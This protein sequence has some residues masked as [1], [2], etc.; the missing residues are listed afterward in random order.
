M[1]NEVTHRQRNHQSISPSRTRGS[2][3]GRTRGPVPVVNGALRPSD[4]EHGRWRA[5][6][7]AVGLG[8]ASA[9]GTRSSAP[10]LAALTS[11]LLEEPEQEA[12][13]HVGEV[14]RGKRILDL[15]LILLALPVL[16]PLFL[17]LA[18][19]I[20]VVS[21]GPIFYSQERVGYRENRFRMLKF[22]SMKVNADTATHQDHTTHLFKSDQPMEKMDHVDP[23]LIP[24]AW[25]LRSTG[26]DELPQLINVWRGDMSLVGP[27][28]CTTY[29]HEVMVPWHKRRFGVLPGLTGL[30]QVNGKNK[31]T[32]QQMINFDIAYAR[33]W[34][35][36]LDLKIMF[37]TFPV[38]LGQLRE[39]MAKRRQAGGLT[40]SQPTAPI[41]PEQA[42]A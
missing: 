29:E 23:R 35:V 41:P 26:I 12:S 21:P 3:R 6:R 40:P 7:L 5:G 34:S 22:R 9:R 39:M 8:L 31:T 42:T 25:I 16:A 17:V 38:L 37:S 4:H 15:A 30:W 2:S 28:P 11:P 14:P 33:Q 32:F 27:R 1:G 10:V 24:F 36:W 19:F 13:W 18:A 20:K